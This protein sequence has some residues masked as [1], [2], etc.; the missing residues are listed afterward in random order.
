MDDDSG[1]GYVLHIFAE[2]MSYALSP[3]VRGETLVGMSA[4]W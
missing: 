1:S 4:P 2:Q 3:S